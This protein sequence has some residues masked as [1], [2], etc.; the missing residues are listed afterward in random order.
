MK[1]IIRLAWVLYIDGNNLGKL[2]SR[3]QTD[4]EYIKVSENIERASISS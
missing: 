1:N 4:Q 3:I 2:Y